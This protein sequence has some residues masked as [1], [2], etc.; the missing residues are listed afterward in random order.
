MS[1]I[2]D[3]SNSRVKDELH[4]TEQLLVSGTS[5]FNTILTQNITVSDTTELADLIVRNITVTGTTSGTDGKVFAGARGEIG[6]PGE[7]GEKGDTVVNEVDMNDP[8]FTGIVTTGNVLQ[9]GESGNDSASKTL[10]FGGVFGDN[11]YDHTVI[12]NRIYTIGT[13]RSELLLYK[14]NDKPTAT[15]PDR[16]RMK[17]GEIRFDILENDNNNRTSE[18]TKLMLTSGGVMKHTA[19]NSS[20]T[21]YGPN[22]D[23]GKLFVGACLD[24]TVPNNATD[25]QVIGTD[26]NL[27]LNAGQGKIVQINLYSPQASVRIKGTV[28]MQDSCSVTG[29]LSCQDLNVNNVSVQTLINNATSRNNPTFTGNQITITGDSPTIR[30]KNGTDINAFIH[31]DQDKLWILSGA[32]TSTTWDQDSSGNY[33]M[34]IDFRANHIDIGGS[35]TVVGNLKCENLVINKRHLITK[36]YPQFST[37]NNSV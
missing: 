10:K 24:R 32:P 11:S 28:T 17:A 33:P 35:C 8:T 21:E 23:N 5:S 1:L 30:F 3:I 4:I 7:K 13:E 31:C 22:T 34:V 36:L 9:L 12:E 26:G 14:G 6:P 15:G 25:A 18:N 19:G 16:I 37:T 20:Y 29:T 2:R 27:H